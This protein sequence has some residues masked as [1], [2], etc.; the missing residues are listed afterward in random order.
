M[1]PAA[2]TLALAAAAAFA[3]FAHGGPTIF[4]PASDPAVT[5][6]GRTHVNADGS[7]SFDWQ[8][9][10]F[11][12]TVTGATFVSINVNSTGAARTRLTCN[13]STGTHGM[14]VWVDR[15][16]NGIPQVIAS[17][18]SGTVGVVA[19]NGVEP[20]YNGAGASATFN[21]MGFTTDG[22]P[23]ST[24]ARAHNIEFIGDS[25]TAGFGSLG[26]ASTPGCQVSSATS[27]NFNSW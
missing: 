15:T 23:S 1:S 25:I 16:T 19:Y 27:S 20:A 2:S 26:S 3:A 24:P 17:G 6:T 11:L 13:V 22:T 21:F 12:L 9:T 5:Y 8:A 10:S 4:V 18:L 14:E 7:R